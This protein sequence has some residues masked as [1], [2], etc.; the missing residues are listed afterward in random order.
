M[1]EFATKVNFGGQD[2][3]KFLARQLTQRNY[4]F[5]NNS[6]CMDLVREIKEKVCRVALD[7]KKVTQSDRLIT[8]GS[9]EDAEI[10]YSATL[11]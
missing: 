11:C 1:M 9:Q 10:Q 2:L 7:Y 5:I 6:A 3:T 4:C 8:V